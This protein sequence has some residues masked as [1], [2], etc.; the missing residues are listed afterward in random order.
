VDLSENWDGTVTL[1]VDA[2]CEMMGNDRV[3]SHELTVR[4][5]ENGVKYLRNDISEE[6]K[7]KI[8]EYYERISVINKYF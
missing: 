4:F 6:E 3:F 2:V 1:T 7:K 8:P 5:T